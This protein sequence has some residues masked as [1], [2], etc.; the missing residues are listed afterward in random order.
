MAEMLFGS[1]N[2]AG[3][4]PQVM[5]AILLCDKGTEAAYGDDA[6]SARVDSAFSEVFERKCF[7]FS[8]PTGTA[9]NALGLSLVTPAYGETI[10]HEASHILTTEGGAPEFYAGG[11]R[12]VG[13]Q[14][15][16]GKL[17]SAELS[18][19]LDRRILP[20]RH[21]LAC[22]SLSL[23]QATE[24]GTVYSLGE[25]SDLSHAARGHG[26]RV[27]MDGA[28]FA[29]ALVALDASPA[30]MSWRAGVDVLSMGTTKNGT[31]NAEAVIVFEA[32]LARELAFRQ[33]R[34]G[35]LASK[36]RYVSAQLLAFLQEDL[37]LHNARRA[38]A[39][40]RELADILARVPGIHLLHPV[41]TNQIFIEID[42]TAAQRL[43]RAGVRFQPWKS[44]GRPSV[45]RLV[46][47]FGDDATKV[48]RV[49]AAVASLTAAA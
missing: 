22:S 32:S 27:H 13:M 12:L 1:D 29:N 48:A 35:L 38:N 37:W 14:G 28:R 2:Q 45:Y 49:E 11:S 41:Q 25:I 20:S 43:E 31:M 19:A 8:T 34:A 6:Y 15:T 10:C 46:A 47:S 4:S 33:K 44:Q 7:V 30:A 26:L 40:A 39:T 5:E 17:D 23:S 24:A 16:S 42:R 9:A 21:H 18:E 36:M 3:I